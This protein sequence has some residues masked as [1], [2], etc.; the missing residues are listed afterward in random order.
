MTKAPQPVTFASAAGQFIMRA[1]WQGVVLAE[2][3]DCVVV[4]G[5]TYF[6]RASV[7]WEYLK[8]T[9]MTSRCFWKGTASYYDVEVNGKRNS[10]AAWEYRK[11]SE[12]A[13]MVK[14]RIGFWRGVEVV[15]SARKPEALGPLS[16][17]SRDPGP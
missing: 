8:P 12:A 3:D 9:D 11:P 2:S 1:T 16:S 14:D 4:D 13:R 5:Y 10:D 15:G 7:R 17:S 6:P